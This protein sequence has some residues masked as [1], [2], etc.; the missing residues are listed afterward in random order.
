MRFAAQMVDALD[1]AHRHGVTHRDL[2]PANIFLVARGAQP[3]AR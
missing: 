2:K 1:Q 3:P